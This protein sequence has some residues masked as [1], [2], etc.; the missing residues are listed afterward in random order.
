VLKQ[1]GFQVYL[2]DGFRSSSICPACNHDLEA[3]RYVRN[4]RSW[5]LESNPWV[6]CHGLLR[7]QNENCLES[8]ASPEGF[9]RR[10]LWSRDIAAVPNLKHILVGLCENKCICERFSRKTPKEKA[11]PKPK[12]KPRHIPIAKRKFKTRP[13]RNP[14]RDL[15]N[16]RYARNPFVHA[17]AASI[18]RFVCN[19]SFALHQLK[20]AQGLSSAM[21]SKRTGTACGTAI[22]AAVLNFDEKFPISSGALAA[23]L[24]LL[25]HHKHNAF[26]NPAVAASSHQQPVAKRQRRLTGEDTN[27]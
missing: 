10:R 20:H 17:S 16:F 25:L 11:I 14:G 9:K 1:H 24:P 15:E 12:R 3:F 7:C 27:C 5:Q 26:G 6:K 8:V 21:A 19:G 4:P 18:R 2:I 22:L 23:Q 13:R